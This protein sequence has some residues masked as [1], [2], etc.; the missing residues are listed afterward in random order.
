MFIF[1]IGFSPFN[2]ITYPLVNQMITT[3]GKLWSFYV[4]QMN[5]TEFGTYV[6]NSNPKRNICWATD[7]IKLYDKIENGK[8]HGLNEQ[9]LQNL[10]KFY[11]NAPE[12]R[13][14]NM[15]PYLD[16]NVKFVANYEDDEKREWL[17]V[18]F[19]HL[20]SVRPRHR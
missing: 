10:L 12:Q 15:K 8:V 16:E 1:F 18:H 4:Y 20:M 13:D 9:V 17:E 19:K 7:S 11:I 3:D 14:Y 5:T 6:L 2:D